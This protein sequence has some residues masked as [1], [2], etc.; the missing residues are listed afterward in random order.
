MC[1]YVF[2]IVGVCKCVPAYVCM[3]VCVRVYACVCSC[4]F[5]YAFVFFCVYL[6]VCMKLYVPGQ[7]GTVT[8][9][10]G[11]EGQLRPY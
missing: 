3:Y 2:V 10:S 9:G 6:C 5:V 8:R 1:E 11:T 7:Q 4:V